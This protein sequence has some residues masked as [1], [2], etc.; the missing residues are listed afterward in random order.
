MRRLCIIPARGGSTG[1]PDK[2]RAKLSGKSLITLAVEKAAPLFDK[3]IFS[4]DSIEYLDEVAN[5]DIENVLC[6]RR[7]HDLATAT[8]TL[9]DVA[10]HYFLQYKKHYLQIWM[11][12]PTFPLIGKEDIE[13]A[14][15]ILDDDGYDSV[16]GITRMEYSPYL[17]LSFD[18]NQELTDWHDSKPRENR[19]SLNEWDYRKVYRPLG[20]YGM[21]MKGFEVKRGF[22]RGKTTG[23][24][25][26]RERA[27]SIKTPLDLEIAELVLGKHK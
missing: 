7:P 21:W 10:T 3:V 24:V 12:L 13:D 6:A 1:Y 26:P 27:I 18:D 11:L 8:A 22:F 5:L 17:A 4:S 23:H 15:K 20:L 2:N 9:D 14:Q 25:V 19:K 16:I